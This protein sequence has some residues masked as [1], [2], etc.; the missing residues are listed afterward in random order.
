MFLNYNLK[1]LA[2]VAIPQL[3]LQLIH[4]SIFPFIP[5]TMNRSKDTT[6]KENQR[7]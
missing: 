2:A 4:L 6:S 1:Y 3:L 7:Y 5:K